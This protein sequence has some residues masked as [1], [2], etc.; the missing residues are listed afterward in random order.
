MR[1]C[2]VRSPKLSRVQP[3]TGYTFTTKK[4]VEITSNC[5]MTELTTRP[6]GNT[7]DTEG[8]GDLHSEA[9][10]DV[11]STDLSARNPIGDTAILVGALCALLLLVRK[12][13]R[14]KKSRK[15]LLPV[16]YILPHRQLFSFELQELLPVP[17]ASSL[18]LHI[19]QLY[20]SSCVK[21]TT[22]DA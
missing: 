1:V 3:R 22:R 12:I 21:A 6:S 4:L 11:S 17:L 19:V 18:K 20:L 16:V 9:D 2:A 14:Q 13:E 8:P 15:G 10:C 7:T 5:R